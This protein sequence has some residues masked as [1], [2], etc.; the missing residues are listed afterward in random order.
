VHVDG[1]RLVSADGQTLILRGISLG[2]WFEPEGYMFGMEGGPQSL[3]EIEDFFNEL[4]GPAEASKFWQAY[5]D[6][7]IT[8]DDIRFVRQTS[9]YTIRIPLHYKFFLPGNSEGSDCLDRMIGWAHHCESPNYFA[10]VMVIVR[11]K[12][13]PFSLPWR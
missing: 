10:G 5:R 2:N 13:C 9:S 1:K 3:R 8:E 11:K 6:A 12:T 7:Y 4:I